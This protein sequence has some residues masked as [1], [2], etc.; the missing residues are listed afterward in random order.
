MAGSISGIGQQQVPLSQPYQPGGTESARVQKQLE[1]REP[2]NN[3]VQ[4]SRT[5]VAAQS[6]ESDT[7]TNA[8][9]NGDAL[10]RSLAS[11]SNGNEQSAPPRGS[12]VNF[13]V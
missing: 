11:A 7:D 6:R 10:S 4:K 13:T 9:S 2:R 8:R 3:E 1:E 5:S 12:V